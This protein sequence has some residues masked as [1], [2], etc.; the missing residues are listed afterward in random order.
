MDMLFEQDLERDPPLQRLVARCKDRPHRALANHALDA[1]LAADDAPDV[2]RQLASRRS[3]RPSRVKRV[4]DPGAFCGHRWQSPEQPTCPALAVVLREYNPV[5]YAQ[6]W[7]LAALELR[8]W[9]LCTRLR[10]KDPLFGNPG[11][12]PESD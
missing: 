11:A 2:R 3:Q 1:I 12:G 6:T 10:K 7:Q 9:R 4:H 5:G 8:L